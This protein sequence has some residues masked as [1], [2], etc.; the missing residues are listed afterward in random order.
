MT[1]EEIYADF[2][3]KML[4]HDNNMAW[5]FYKYYSSLP[6]EEGIDLII[7]LF[8]ET[9]HTN[10]ENIATFFQGVRNPLSADILFK[11]ALREDI[12]QF[13]YKPL[14]RKCTWALADIG[15][16]KAKY[17]L[18]Q[19]ANSEDEV[20]KQFA[21]KTLTNWDKELT[22]K[23]QRITKPNNSDLFILLENYTDSIEQLP[24]SGQQLI[25]N[26]QYDFVVVYQAYKDS[27]ADFAVKNQILG[28]NDFSYNRMS[29]IKPNFL[30]MMY[31]CGWAEKKDQE[32]VL[33]FWISKADFFE[34]LQSATFTSFNSNH[35]TNED[36]WRKELD[37]NNVRIQWDPDHDPLGNK[38]NRR[39]IQLGLKEEALKKF[40]KEQIKYVMDITDFVK[41]QKYY[42]DK[43]QLD[44]LL[45]P[46]ERIINL[47]NKT[48]EA[49]IDITD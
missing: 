43:K 28:G 31:R 13:E 25:G 48:L 29:W 37:K 2:E 18:I 40:G 4:S 32:R 8:N 45:I 39:A 1:Q 21:A 3:N 9:W 34:I 38:I 49:K 6:A 17:Y 22:R 44:K 15:T 24:K 41:E 27:I 10:H 36:E 42:I 7:K 35:F 16:E 30:W 12:F 26:T 23:G 33:A 11:T 47:N 20:V 19:L 46:I 5:D 14:S